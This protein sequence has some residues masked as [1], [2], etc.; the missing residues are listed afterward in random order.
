MVGEDIAQDEVTEAT[1]A[2]FGQ[3]SATYETN[4]ARRQ[5]CVD[6]GGER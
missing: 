2:T 6:E 4:R 5:R 3:E 1:E